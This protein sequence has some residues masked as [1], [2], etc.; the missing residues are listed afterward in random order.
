MGP[1]DT[2]LI[3]EETARRLLLRK[4]PH[5]RAIVNATIGERWVVHP[6][7]RALATE[8]PGTVATTATCASCRRTLLQAEVAP[9]KAADSRASSTLAWRCHRCWQWLCG[10]CAMATRSAMMPS[11]SR[12]FIP[13]FGYGEF[14]P[15]GA[16]GPAEIA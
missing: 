3:D 1:F 11:Q 14:W 5:D 10:R 13:H 6:Q 7:C 15:P 4:P 16:T 2:D 8:T 12:D 9:R